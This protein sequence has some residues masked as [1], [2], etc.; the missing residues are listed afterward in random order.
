ME[1]GKLSN[2]VQVWKKTHAMQ[3]EVYLPAAWGQGVMQ[4]VYA[5]ARIP[6]A[7]PFEL[8]APQVAMAAAVMLLAVSIPCFFTVS[9]ALSLLD[10][11][12]L[13]AGRDSAELFLLL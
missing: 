6:K 7:S 4:D 13:D 1:K 2:L 11:Q 5:A 3:T 8:F 9:N 12:L 10:A